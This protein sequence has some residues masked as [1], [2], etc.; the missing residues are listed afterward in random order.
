MLAIRAMREG[1]SLN[2]YCQKILKK[3]A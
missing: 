1:E 3:A 2:S